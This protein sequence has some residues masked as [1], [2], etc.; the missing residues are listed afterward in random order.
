MGQEDP[1]NLKDVQGNIEAGS[2][3]LAQMLEK[4]GGNL[5]KALAAYNAGP[6]AV[7]KY[8]GV[9]PYAET[10]GYVSKVLST[11]QELGGDKPAAEDSFSKIMEARIKAVAERAR[12]VA[13]TEL[14]KLKD[15]YEKGT[16]GVSEYY[17]RRREELDKTYQAEVK[18][19]NDKLALEDSDAEKIGLQNDL[20]VLRLQHERDLIDL[21]NERGDA[22]KRAKQKAAEDAA[23]V[24]EMMIGL[25]LTSTSESDLEDRH[26]AELDA[27][28]NYAETYLQHLVKFHADENQLNEA[29]DR[30]ERQRIQKQVEQNAETLQNKIN[31]AQDLASGFGEIFSQLY[32]A[33]GE[34]N[35]EWLIAVRAAQIAEINIK[36]ATAI[37]DIWSKYYDEP[38]KGAA[39]TALIVAQ[40][41]ASLAAIAAQSFAT[42]GVVQGWSPSKTADNIPARLTAGEYVMPVDAVKRYGVGFFEALRRQAIPDDLLV[43]MRFPALPVHR[44]AHAFATGG[45]A[46]A[47]GGS[48]DVGTAGGRD[49]KQEFTIINV[50]DPRELDGY[51]ASKRGQDAI[52]NVMSSRMGTIRKMLK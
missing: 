46:T 38:W 29:Q 13:E 25:R 15:M 5:E 45:L 34:K 22:E 2:K 52:L 20:V 11:Y 9:P 26:Q 18:A 31:F 50:T 3:Y 27:F 43:N 44:P 51:L 17:D 39:Y 12:A 24:D 47:G 19:I 14:A 4:F 36:A 8:G 23:T 32:A 6:G 48:M 40:K 10:Q 28:D 16:L 35:K 1:Y 41:Y 42:G 21:I 49:A 7:Q 30:L 33:S 37:V